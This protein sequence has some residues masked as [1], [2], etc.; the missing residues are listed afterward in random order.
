MLKNRL[1]IAVPVFLAFVCLLFLSCGGG[2][3]GEG[4]GE[5][6]GEGGDSSWYDSATGL[7]WQNPPPDK[8]LLLQ[9]ALDYCDSLIL[10][11]YNDWRLPAIDE[12]RSLIRGCPATAAGGGCNVGAACSDWDCRNDPCSGCEAGNGPTDGAYWPEEMEGDWDSEWY[13]SSSALG[14][15]YAWLVNFESGA[16]DTHPPAI[17]GDGTHEN[18]ELTSPVRCVR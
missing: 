12:L 17:D 4:E 16:V 15:G 1:F 3:S 10:D 2:D 8:S 13:W 7:T 11:G 6:E 5:G 9:D 14:G 18:G